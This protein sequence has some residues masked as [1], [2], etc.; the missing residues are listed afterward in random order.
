MVG[1]LAPNAGARG[2]GNWDPVV[3]FVRVADCVHHR[4]LAL[5]PPAWLKWRVSVGS[6]FLVL[7]SWFWV[8]G[9][10][11]LVLGFGFGFGAPSVRHER[12]P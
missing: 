4:L 5:M 7:G 9:F 12:R 6:W 10:G 11:F 8:L 3:P 2:V 1:L